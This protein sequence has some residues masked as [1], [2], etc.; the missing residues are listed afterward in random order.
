[1]NDDSFFSINKLVEFGMGMAVAQQMVQSMNTVIQQTQV[2]GVNN[3]MQTVATAEIV[4]YAILEGNQ[5]SPFSESEVIRLI[6]NKKIGNQTYIWKLGM[7]DWDV[8]QNI[9]EIVRLV[10]LNPPAFKGE[11]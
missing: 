1:M 6:E 9:P 11:A 3:P 4:Y 7:S 8:A 2:P 10:A 5:A